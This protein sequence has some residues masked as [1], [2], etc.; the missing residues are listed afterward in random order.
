MRP[1]VLVLAVVLL[2]GCGGGSKSSAQFEAS[3]YAG[4]P[5]S[6][7]SPPGFT[8]RDQHGQLVSLAGQH[9]RYVVV[10]FLYTHC[11]DVC[12]LIATQLNGALRALGPKRADMRVLAVSVDPKGDT[13]TAV[14]RFIRERGLLPQFLYLTGTRAQLAPIWKS[15]HVA[16]GT[17]LSAKNSFHSAYE[18]LFDPSG[19]ARLLYSSDVR[20]SDV[21]HDLQRLGLS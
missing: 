1:L 14:K 6:G 15:W 10:T 18:L 4:S 13:P 2:A 5:W 17:A 21:L 19:K 7:P 11:P 12:P 16:V 3:P 9:G 20:S 8:L